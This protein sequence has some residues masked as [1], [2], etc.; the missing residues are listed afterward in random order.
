M[1]FTRSGRIVPVTALLCSVKFYT[2]STRS[3]PLAA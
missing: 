2:V 3:H 1:N